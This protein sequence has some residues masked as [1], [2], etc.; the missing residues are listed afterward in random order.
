MANIDFAKGFVSPQTTHGGA[1]HTSA[2]KN[3]AVAIFKG[4]VV[5]KDGSGRVL[6]IDA[7]TDVP[8]GVAAHYV[9]ATGGQII[10]V[11]DDLRNTTFEAQ[12]DANEVID[13]TQVGNF[14]DFGAIAT[15]DTTRLTSK[16][17][18]DSN[19]SVRDSLILVE[20]IKRPDNDDSLTKNVARFMF[21]VDSQAHQKAIEA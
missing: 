20:M 11:H 16:H 21:R 7:I 17:L 14:F 1:V 6:A 2:Y 19:A 4:D 5:K 9:S 3:T 13:D 10:H 18:V 15:G 8:M 12:F